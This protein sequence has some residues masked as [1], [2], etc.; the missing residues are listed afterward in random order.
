MLTKVAVD[1]RDGRDG[2]TREDPRGGH[3]PGLLLV[4]LRFRMGRV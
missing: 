4:R 3:H 1:D 2:H